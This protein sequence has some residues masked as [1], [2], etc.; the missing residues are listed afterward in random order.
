MLVLFVYCMFVLGFLGRSVCS[1]R[2]YTVLSSDWVRFEVWMF[3]FL[4]L[5]GVCGLEFVDGCVC[6]LEGEEI[7]E[8]PRS[9]GG[10]EEQGIGG[11]N[12][13]HLLPG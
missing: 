6:V 10:G 1:W 7:V 9:T 8:E 2:D 3:V 5:L 11:V 13:R 12:C 4:L